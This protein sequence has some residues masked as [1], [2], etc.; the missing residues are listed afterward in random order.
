MAAGLSPLI[1]LGVISRAVVV[2]VLD[3]KSNASF[4]L[5]DLV[6]VKNLGQQILIGEPGKRD[7]S[8]MT[9][10][11]K[12]IITFPNI[13][14]QLTSVPYLSKVTDDNK[15]QFVHV[16]LVKIHLAQGLRE[17]TAPI[18]PEIKENDDF[19]FKRI[20]SRQCKILSIWTYNYPAFMYCK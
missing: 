12:K 10:P 15:I 3:T 1:I 2:Q 9:N 17:F 7:N 19:F 8:I 13:H 5:W 6:V 18:S 20:V 16:L 4:T 14:G 11:V